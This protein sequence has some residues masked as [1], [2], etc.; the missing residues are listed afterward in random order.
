MSNAKHNQKLNVRPVI[1]A[2]KAHAKAEIAAH[3]RFQALVWAIHENGLK[4]LFLERKSRLTKVEKA[5]LE[6]IMKA[7]QQAYGWADISGQ[8]ARKWKS[9][10]K[11]ELNNPGAIAA[12]AKAAR[13]KAKTKQAKPEGGKAAKPESGKAAKPEGGKAA[14]PESD[15]GKVKPTIPLGRL[16]EAVAALLDAETLLTGIE[17]HHPEIQDDLA[18]IRHKITAARHMLRVE[19]K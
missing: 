15:K 2:I 14:K 11:K 3:T 12:A 10:V 1:S 19:T 18:T 16:Q 6:T 17:E 5:A 7:A 8:A 9:R 4:R 13:E